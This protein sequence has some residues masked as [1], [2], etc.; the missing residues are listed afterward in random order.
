MVVTPVRGSILALLKLLDGGDGGLV[1][2]RLARIA[3]TLPFR[4]RPRRLLVGGHMP[5]SADDGRE[6]PY[7]IAQRYARGE[8]SRDEVIRRLAEYDYP[9][10]DT[11]PD[12][13]TVD[14]AEYLA[15]ERTRARYT[16]ST[17]CGRSTRTATRRGGAVVRCRRCSARHRSGGSCQPGPM[18]PSGRRARHSHSPGESRIASAERM[19]PGRTARELPGVDRSDY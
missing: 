4:G 19:S 6:S 18:A 2:G 5:D 11:I 7:Q 17:A 16:A 8:I 13:M 10:Q 14:V 9:P 12:D 15:L 1:R 3:T